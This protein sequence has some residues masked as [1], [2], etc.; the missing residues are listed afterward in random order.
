MHKLG[1]LIQSYNLLILR[2][3]STGDMVKYLFI[4]L[5]CGQIV[6]CFYILPLF[7]YMHSIS[8]VS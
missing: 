7:L 1:G 2:A 8:F 4:P 6:G 3:I 5:F